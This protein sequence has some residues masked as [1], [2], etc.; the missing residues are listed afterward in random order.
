MIRRRACPVTEEVNA[1]PVEGR[2]TE[3]AAPDEGYCGGRQRRGIPALTIKKPANCAAGFR[4]WLPIVDT[5]RTFCLAPSRE[6]RAIFEGTDK[7][8]PDLEG[9]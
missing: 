1:S 2:E 9:R 3:T 8:I 7:M 4:I 5:Y 6:V